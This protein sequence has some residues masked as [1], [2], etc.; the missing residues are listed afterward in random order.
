LFLLSLFVLSID[1]FSLI[2]QDVLLRACC[3]LAVGSLGREIERL[4]FVSILF[5]LCRL[6]F[7]NCSVLCLPDGDGFCRYL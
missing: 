3:V 6:G 5:Y 2:L 1:R 4:F 7:F